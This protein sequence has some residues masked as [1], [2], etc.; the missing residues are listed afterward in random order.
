MIAHLK[1]NILY[2][3]KLFNLPWWQHLFFDSPNADDRGTNSDYA[4]FGRGNAIF[5]YELISLNEDLDM[6]VYEEIYQT[7]L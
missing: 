2:Q 6:K 5:K 3:R 1:G 4:K 7:I